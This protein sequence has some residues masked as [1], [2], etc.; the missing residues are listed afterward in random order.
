MYTYLHNYTTYHMLRFPP[1]I[2]LKMGENSFCQNVLIQV[3]FQKHLDGSQN[4]VKM[5]KNT[6]LLKYSKLLMSKTSFM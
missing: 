1:H 3:L 4:F 2:M 6:F 5:N